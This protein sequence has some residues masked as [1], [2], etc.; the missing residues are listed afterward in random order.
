MKTYKYLFVINH[1]SVSVANQFSREDGGYV[2][3]MQEEG[4]ETI[5]SVTDL[6]ENVDN[7]LF[8]MGIRISVVNSAKDIDEGASKARIMANYI[9]VILS[10]ISNASI[11]EPILELGY[12][13]T[14][15]AMKTEFMQ[16]LYTNG[17]LFKQKRT[18]DP[19]MFDNLGKLLMENN[20]LRIGRAIRW[21]RMGLNVK[22][23]IDKFMYYW[24]GLECLNNLIAKELNATPKT[25]R[26]KNCGYSYKN[27]TVNG[28]E[29]LFENYSKEKSDYAKC[30]KLRNELQHG[31]GDLKDAVYV[32]EQYSEI[33]RKML[34]QGIYLL[35]NIDKTIIDKH[36]D[37]L[38]NLN[39]PCIEFRGFHDISP[40][41]LSVVP[42][43]IIDINDIKI[44]FPGNKMAL[45]YT[46]RIDT[47]IPVTME[48]KSINFIAEQGVSMK[49]NDIK[50]TPKEK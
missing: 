35:L 31:Y 42:Y 46:N 3:A 36:M 13:I 44:D 6:K 20:S 24:V 1:S 29:A 48:L 25:G 18:I 22:D 41:D 16:F 5:I 49:I 43:L 19:F 8:H 12:E 4:R 50:L 30:K 32:A 38:Y 34:L 11:S 47:N 23:S 15:S 40:K 17:E 2:I 28:I 14:E 39:M 21:Y 27:P 10:F 45:S 9:A 26:C 7:I 37:P 33:C